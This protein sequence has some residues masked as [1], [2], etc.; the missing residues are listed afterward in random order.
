[1][2]QCYNIMKHCVAVGGWGANIKALNRLTVRGS[3]EG[4]QMKIKKKWA[5][6]PMAALMLVAGGFAGT[7]A[8][9]DEAEATSIPS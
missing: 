4:K 7:A 2:S 8:Q 3:R 1:M 9:A 6:G 5:A